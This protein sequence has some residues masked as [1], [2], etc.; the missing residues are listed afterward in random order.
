ME[1]FEVNKYLFEHI[2]LHKFEE[3]IQTINKYGSEIDFNIRDS[4]NTYLIQYAVMYNNINLVKLILHFNCK[5]DF[6]DADGHT[7]LYIPIKHGYNDIIKL[8]IENNDIIGVPLID[9]VD[10][11]GS[12]AIHYTILYDN[13]DAF[14]LLMDNNV[15]INKTDIRGNTALHIAI[16]RKNYYIVEKILKCTRTNPNIQSNI[17]ESPLHIAANYEDEK[18]MQLL[19]SLRKDILVDLIDYEYQIT[20]LMY[21]STLNNISLVTMLLNAGADPEIQDSLGNSSLHLAII[22]DNVPIA[23]ILISKFNNFNIINIDGMTPLHKLLYIYKDNTNKI[24]QFNI[25]QLFNKTNINMQDID[26]NTIWHILAKDGM[27]IRYKYLLMN[28]K[29]NI[30]I[31]NSKNITAYDIITEKSSSNLELLMEIITH[32]Y[33]NLLLIGKN[34]YLLDWENDCANKL[35]PIKYCYEKIR[36]NVLKNKVSIPAK[37]TAYC[38][39]NIEHIDDVVMYSTFTGVAID[40]VAG[41]SLL[42]NSNSGEIVTSLNNRNI[43]HNEE[44]DQYYRQLGIK[45]N[46]SDFLNFEIVWLYQHIFFIN[47]LD[48]V[49]KLYIKNNKRLLIIPVGI[50]L[51]NGAHSNMLIYDRNTNTMERFEPNGADAPPN[52]NYNAKQLDKLIYNYFKSYFPHMKYLSAKDISPKIGF[53]AF[54]QVEHYK[55]RQL[56]DPNGFCA[57]WCIWYAM[58]R[59]KHPNIEPSRLITTLIKKIK[60]NNFSFKNI[61]R[62]FAKEITDY[63]DD[64]LNKVGLNINMYLNNQYDADTLEKLASYIIKN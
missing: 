37:K 44:I 26:G 18:S 29:N 48:T 53:Q 3:V 50:E 59:S 7:I 60:Y 58:Q 46:N 36:E 51:A 62:R 34:E 19:L 56:G 25:D 43:V 16:K 55:L 30:F 40:I 27:W 17:G 11:L 45:K 54:E 38:N 24:N 1:L 33:Y 52:Y 9:I 22:E 20:P 21:L 5:L 32:S 61:I 49:I 6:I 23:N 63:R 4:S 14:D 41:L 57:A 28:K 39:V 10:K 64:L 12:L 15:N 2:K 31:K 13:N 8:L 47:D 35:K 42:H